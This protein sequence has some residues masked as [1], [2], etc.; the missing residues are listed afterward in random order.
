MQGSDSNSA[1]TLK[2]KFGIETILNTN[3]H[4]TKREEKVEQSNKISPRINL[5]PVHSNCN[6]EPAEQDRC[7][8]S[9]SM[10]KK[11]SVLSSERKN[12]LVHG[13]ISPAT[14]LVDSKAMN[15]I[16]EN[17]KS[18][19]PI[20]RHHKVFQYHPYSPT[21]THS[22]RCFSDSSSSLESQDGRPIR[23]K[24]ESPNYRPFS[25]VHSV[26]YNYES[27]EKKLKPEDKISNSCSKTSY[28]LTWK[29]DL[30]HSSKKKSMSSSLPPHDTNSTNFHLSSSVVKSERRPSNHF[31]RAC[32]HEDDQHPRRSSDSD[33]VF[34][35]SERSPTIPKDVAS[36]W[37]QQHLTPRGVTSSTSS[38]PGFLTSPDQLKRSKHSI[39]DCSWKF[40]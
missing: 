12:T 26:N 11:Q 39:F 18:T 15:G 16:R 33:E 38:S 7:L 30:I 34:N 6:S 3:S 8:Q 10:G 4:L 31:L 23:G 13:K 35:E 1:A 9:E 5:S 17:F 22:E 40:Y 29:Q 25:Q 24:S 2:L 19:S 20:R 32:S 21:K 36:A 27:N 28:N 37:R 14:N